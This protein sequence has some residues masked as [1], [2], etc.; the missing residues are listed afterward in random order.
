MRPKKAIWTRRGFIYGVSAAS[1]GL[2]QSPLERW[3]WANE[4]EGPR[5]FVSLYFSGG[6][7]VLL[8]PDTRAPG[9]YDGIE[10]GTALLAPR[11][12]DPVVATVGGTEMLWGAPMAA[13]LPHADVL[14]LF[15]G[16]NMNTVAHPTGQAYVNSFI[17][18]SGVTVNGDSLGT[19]FASVGDYDALIMPNFVVGMPTFNDTMPP[20]LTGITVDRARD[21]RRLIGQLGPP[22][23]LSQTEELLRT[24]QREAR[25]CIV[26]GPELELPWEVLAVSR[27]RMQRMLEENLASA[28]EFSDEPAI[29]A[30]Y[31]IVDPEDS[32]DP[33]VVAATV[34]RV[35]QTGLSRTVTARLQGDLDQH[36]DWAEYHP[37]RLEAG[38][39]ATAALLDDLRADDPSLERTT[40]IVHSEF[41]R[42]PLLNGQRGRDHH[43][44]NSILVFGGG[45]RRG[46]CGETAEQT[47]GLVTI[48][49]DTGLAKE[50]GHMLVPEDIGA[51]LAQAA[52]LPPDDFHADPL[53]SWIQD[54]V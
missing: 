50:G 9:S 43:F 27:E 25:S 44:A 22:S 48:D 5:R 37:Y 13:L 36:S 29:R 53:T 35:L 19:R 26:S 23:A 46:V 30:R 21:I 54:P 10:L 33:G 52:G 49:R 28:F 47:L 2:L 39:A 14:T 45:L 40:V 32:E 51:T 11:H 6:W 17:P 24:A 16:V 31:G 41:A 15:R 7:D 3:S 38:F 18:P 1:W 34:W 12:R 8:G 20:E 4:I 42:T